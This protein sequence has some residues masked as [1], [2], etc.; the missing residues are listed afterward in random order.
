MLQ[1][2]EINTTDDW[3][4]WDFK[5]SEY[6]HI[7]LGFSSRYNF[8][9]SAKYC[10][11]ATIAPKQE[12]IDYMVVEGYQKKKNKQH[13]SKNV[14]LNDR[15]QPGNTNIRVMTKKFMRNLKPWHNQIKTNFKKITVKNDWKEVKTINRTILDALPKETPY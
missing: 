7:P 9:K 10:N 5:H 11:L 3:T 13:I 8:Y 1:N 2:F 4:H 6:G 14:K 15:R 12:E